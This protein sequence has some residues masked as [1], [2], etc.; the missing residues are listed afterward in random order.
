MV[1]NNEHLPRLAHAV[2]GCTLAVQC[3]SLACAEQVHLSTPGTHAN[4]DISPI[5]ITVG[6]YH[7]CGGISHFRAVDCTAS[8]GRDRG[9]CIAAGEPTTD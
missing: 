9:V 1:V 7:K 3:V 6:G 5:D 4:P 8:C 2:T